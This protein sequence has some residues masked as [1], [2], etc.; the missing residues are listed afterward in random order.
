MNSRARAQKEST[1]GG[2]GSELDADELQEVHSQILA[3]LTG[4][5]EFIND[6]QLISRT[7]SKIH[8]IPNVFDKSSKVYKKSLLCSSTIADTASSHLL[9]L[10]TMRAQRYEIVTVYLKVIHQ[11]TLWVNTS[12]KQ[13]SSKYK[14][15]ARR[16][17]TPLINQLNKLTFLHGMAIDITPL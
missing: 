9:S 1:S 3:I 17:T 10:L 5:I 16:L 14:M 8:M 13:M 15:I 12:Y 11:T 6:F 2:G 7:I 4:L